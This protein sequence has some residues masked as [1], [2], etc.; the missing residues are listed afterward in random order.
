MLTAEQIDRH[1]NDGYLFPFPALSS[2]EVATCSVGLQR[3]ERWLGEWRERR[4]AAA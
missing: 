2:D 4:F 3:F 1:R